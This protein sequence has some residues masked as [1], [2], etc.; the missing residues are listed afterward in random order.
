[1]LFCACEHLSSDLDLAPQVF[2]G[3]GKARRFEEYIVIAFSFTGDTCWNKSWLKRTQESQ[4]KTNKIR[5][6]FYIT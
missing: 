1:M 5:D 3:I 2:Y 4:I 6:L